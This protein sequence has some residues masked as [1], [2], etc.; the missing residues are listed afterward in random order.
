MSFYWF[1]KIEA[2]LLLVLII[3][4]N[5][6]DLVAENTI[7]KSDSN[8]LH[9]K[10]LIDP[11]MRIFVEDLLF[12]YWEISQLPTQR[13]TQMLNILSAY[14]E[15]PEFALQLVQEAFPDLTMRQ[16]SFYDAYQKARAAKFRKYSRSL[17]PYIKGSVLADVGGE[18]SRLVEVLTSMIP[19]VEKAYVT[20][21]NMPRHE[22]GNPKIEFLWQSL[23]EKTPLEKE[24]VDSVILSTVLHHINPF[25]RL[26]LVIHLKEILRNGGRLILIEDTYPE[27]P[28]EMD[29]H[30]SLDERFLSFGDHQK[31]Q[32][33]SFLDW[34]GNRLMKNSR[35]IP[36]PC[37][38]KSMEEWETYFSEVGLKLVEKH[39]LGI[40][41]MHTHVMA[42]KGILIFEKSSVDS[43]IEG[44]Q[45]YSSV[46]RNIARV[47][48]NREMMAFAPKT[49]VNI[50]LSI[51]GSKIQASVI[52][53]DMNELVLLDEYCWRNEFREDQKMNGADS[54]Q[55]RVWL[56]DRI[57][58]QI[59]A[60]KEKLQEKAGERFVIEGVGLAWAGPVKP[61]GLV[62]GPNIDGFK[63]SDLN[64]QERASGGIKLADL[65]RSRLEDTL[66]ASEIDIQLF[67]DGD[68]AALACFKAAK[69]S[70]GLL[71][72]IGTGIGS[73]IVSKDKVFYSANGFQD[74][75]GEIGHH[76]LYHQVHHRYF[77][78][79]MLTK[80]RIAEE[81]TPY[82]FSQRLA[83]PGLA[84]K[85]ITRLQRELGYNP[86]TVHV[87]LNSTEQSTGIRF[88]EIELEACDQNSDIGPSIEKKLIRLI[89]YKALKGDKSAISFIKEV[90]YEV[91]LGIG[92]FIKEFENENFVRNL[93]I[94][95]SIGKHF[96]K[97]LVDENGKDLFLSQILKG[98]DWS[99]HHHN[100]DMNPQLMLELSSRT[101]DENRFDLDMRASQKT[102]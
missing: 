25:V 71:L 95:G 1:R 73:G 29:I 51:G 5:K 64:D 69:L 27:N 3:V 10:L 97:G 41:D 44:V 26:Q 31:K 11:E 85:F 20:D 54:F 90:G 33:I 74:R 98:I 32:I 9:L 13:L 94:S 80:G 101:V 2:I 19:E 84:K 40:P 35:D 37:T 81:L 12:K 59:A 47:D 45:E 96:G 72:T 38:F 43:K 82:S 18:D 49:G 62:I 42:P 77:Y 76:I 61:N 79:G 78:Y 57:I 67:N 70:D 23:P 100:T 93:I 58:N 22:S 53:K 7:I 24:S 15:E 63:F 88:S 36:L 34:W 56:V 102:N 68:A 99:I 75:I 65:I 48:K 14:W 52:D 8:K 6:A 55:K 17:V 50:N 83:G 60:A 91:G 87:F 28:T 39:Y 30:N 86:E 92:V 21:I 46:V 89:S 4:F 66:K 16:S